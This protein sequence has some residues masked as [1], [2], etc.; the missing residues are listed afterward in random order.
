MWMLLLLLLLLP[1]PAP[2]V[3]LFS[4]SFEGP[5]SAVGAR[6]P[7]QS[8]SG[9]PCSGV[10]TLSTSQVIGGTQ[11]LEQFFQ[12]GELH[13]GFV[14]AE[15]ADQTRTDIW[16]S[17]WNKLSVGFCAGGDTA[18]G[19]GGVGTKTIYMF[20]RSP[21]TGKFMGWVP[22][23]MWGGLQH[24]LGTQGCRQNDN[25]FLYDSSIL[26][27]NVNPH[28]QQPGL[29]YFHEVHYKFD[30]AGN[31][32]SVIEEYMTPQGGQTFLATR[33]T[34]RDCLDNDTSGQAPADLAWYKIRLYRQYGLG[35][36]YYDDITVSTERIG[37]GGTVP[38]PPP[39]PPPPDT[40]IP[41]A[42]SDL[43]VTEVWERLCTWLAA[44]WFWISPT[45]AYAETASDQ[46]IVISWQNPPTAPADAQIELWLSGFWLPDE[47]TIATIPITP[48]TYT[49][50]LPMLPDATDRWVCVRARYRFVNGLVGGYSEKGCNQVKV[51]AP[52]PVPV[53]PPPPDPAPEPVP[54]PAP[55]IEERLATLEQS[56]E[57][58]I[59]E[60]NAH[61]MKDVEFRLGINASAAKLEAIKQAVCEL[62]TASTLRTALRTALGATGC[63]K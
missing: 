42:P 9:F 11:S 34:G 37:S 45:A 38:P 44:V 50:P 6:W 24:T 48:A 13:G 1:A 32:D 2:A 40:T 53:P 8:Y 57:T 16:I 36:I 56:V 7:A 54:P 49:Y 61:A 47:I 60:I 58:L 10:M 18:C 20:A 31:N 35:Q 22:N 52:T 33:Y 30:G 25:G 15:F 28:A 62:R 29:W 59:T 23:Y 39:P 26:Y 12:G 19:V 41:A 3:T 4:E 63:A 55:S 27:Q 14:D 43:R 5:C 46:Q 51:S 17:F 21:S